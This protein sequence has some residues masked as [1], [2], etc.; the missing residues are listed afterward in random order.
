M[1]ALL[2]DPYTNSGWFDSRIRW[3]RHVCFVIEML[4]LGFFAILVGVNSLLNNDPMLWFPWSFVAII[5]FMITLVVHLFYYV[6][7]SDFLGD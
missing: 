5:V 3:Q 2:F 6:V 1:L 4:G 7:D